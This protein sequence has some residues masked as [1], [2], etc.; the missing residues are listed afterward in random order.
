MTLL[1]L[2]ASQAL[3]LASTDSAVIMNRVR[4]DSLFMKLIGNYLSPY[5]RRVAITLNAFEIPFELEPV[6]IFKSPEKVEPHNPLVRIPTLILD[7]DEVLID[8]YVIL[9]AI[10]DM[11]GPERALTPRSGE[12]R[13]RVMKITAVGVG[14]AE[15]AQWAFY[16]SRFHPPEK[17]HPPWVEHND[18]QVV[19]GLGYL[20][21]LASTAGDSGWLAGTDAMS[22]ADITAVVTFSFASKIR[23]ELELGAKA[24][25]LAALAGRCEA[26]HMFKAAPLPDELPR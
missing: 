24:P 22:Q 20:D 19:R 15:K 3:G 11:M 12:A 17:V 1:R 16:E 23:P 26:L 9:D 13:R 10:D 5:V 6:F 14:S 7:D 25:H 21:E 2:K 18:N 8:S 4:L